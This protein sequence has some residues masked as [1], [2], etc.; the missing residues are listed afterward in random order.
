MLHCFRMRKKLSALITSSVKVCLFSSTFYIS[1]SSSNILL[2]GR[3]FLI[4]NSITRAM[5]SMDSLSRTV[6]L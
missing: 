2:T 6:G 3:L 4:K 1:T 5:I